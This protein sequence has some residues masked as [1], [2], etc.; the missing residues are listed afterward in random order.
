MSVTKSLRGVLAALAVAGGMLFAASAPA[1]ATALVYQANNVT[2]K[3]S[4]GE[5]I[6]LNQCIND[7]KDGVIQTQLNA[8]QQIST[9]GNLLQ[10]EN[11][12]V[13]VLP[14]S[15]IGFPLFASSHV[16]VE[17]SGGLANAIN[18]CVNDA[19]DGF[20]QTQT[21]ACAQSASAGNIVSLIGVFVAVYQ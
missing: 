12:S 11:V 20:I 2:V 18:S 19:Q 21:N 9:A 3:V 16:T 13:W 4:G 15:G 17:V 5:A 14:P 6:A 7:A 8:C 10:L 1:S